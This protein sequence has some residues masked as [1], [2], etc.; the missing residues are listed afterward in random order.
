MVTST[1][2]PVT[3]TALGTKQYAM[4]M[5][6]EAFRAFYE[7]TARQLW[8]YLLHLTRNEA[9][10]DDLLQESYCRLLSAKLAAMDECRLRSYLFRIATN[11]VRDRWRRKDAS[12]VEVVPDLPGRTADPDMT[13]DLRK[14]LANLRPRERQMLWLAYVEGWDHKEIAKAVG[15]TSGSI[16]LLL[17]RVRR[18]L[19]T[20]LRGVS[21]LE[22]EKNQ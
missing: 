9:I 3:S 12:A 11:L 6:Q 4:G 2:L 8:A 10:A 13:L 15:L 17:F 19:A 20:A 7:K 5:D 16:R 22:M 1:S 14:A 21:E 18:K